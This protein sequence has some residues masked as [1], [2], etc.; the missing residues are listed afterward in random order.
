MTVAAGR[1]PRPATAR[2]PATR[3]AAARPSDAPGAARRHRV[4]GLNARGAGAEARRFLARH[5]EWTVLLAAAAAWV[6]LL[7]PW[8]STPS[9]G[10]LGVATAAPHHQ[11]QGG[12]VGPGWADAWLDPAPLATG[13]TSIV[14]GPGAWGHWGLMIVA[15]MLP[16]LVPPVRHAAFASPRRR[17]HRTTAL[18]VAAYLSLWMVVGLGV[19][20]AVGV[21]RPGVMAAAAVLVAA[22]AW[23]LTPVVRRA[24]ARCHRSVPLG[25]EGST[26]DVAALRFGWFHARA[27]AITCAPFMAALTVAG[28]PLWL[29]LGIA[30]VTC[31]QKL[32]ADAGRWV[33]PVV[34]L[35]VLSA[36]VLVG[37]G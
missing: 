17:R 11:L 30:T 33:H 1:A 10:T 14:Q 8:L 34:V 23:E 35:G 12:D 6:L 4:R 18:F 19:T 29:T 9:P 2:V 21:L 13:W 37:T 7:G 27:C 22:S 24:L 16:G 28:H 26:A 20:F 25:T 3:P 36:V 31:L 32:G 15:M 5:P